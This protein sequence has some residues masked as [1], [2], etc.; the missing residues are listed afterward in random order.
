MLQRQNHATLTPTEADALS[1]RPRGRNPPCFHPSAAAATVA[2]VTLLPMAILHRPSHRSHHRCVSVELGMCHLNKATPAYRHTWRRWRRK[3]ICTASPPHPL[4]TP[5]SHLPSPQLTSPPFPSSIFHS[6][7]FYSLSLPPN[8]AS[9]LTEGSERQV[10]ESEDP[11]QR[12]VTNCEG[13]RRGRRGRWE[14]SCAEK[15]MTAAGFEPAPFL[16]VIQLPFSPT[17]PSPPS[18]PH[19]LITPPPHCTERHAKLIMMMTRWLVRSEGSGSA[20]R[21]RSGGVLEVVVWGAKSTRAAGK[22]A[23]PGFEPGTSRTRSANHTPR[24][25]S[26]ASPSPHHHTPHHHPTFSPPPPPGMPRRT[27]GGSDETDDVV[28]PWEV[29][30]L[31]PRWRRRPMGGSMAGCARVA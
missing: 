7:P 27:Y 22:R 26:R 24:P 2:P 16:T 10:R 21:R 4:H 15:E 3:G 13:G 9:R 17:P 20:K 12:G 11:S 31:V 5:S 23:Q 8:L 14:E 29:A 6:F 28:L 30:S 19:P 25:L 18:P 1:I